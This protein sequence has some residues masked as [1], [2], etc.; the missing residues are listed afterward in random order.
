MKA[1]PILIVIIFMLTSVLLGIPFGTRDEVTYEP[2]TIGADHYIF[3]TFF[4][5][6]FIDMG[7][8]GYPGAI[9]VQGLIP[10]FVLNLSIALIIFIMLRQ[11]KAV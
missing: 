11:R 8:Y 1:T 6:D 5:F 2:G 4:N 10:A 3:I 9:Y 7:H